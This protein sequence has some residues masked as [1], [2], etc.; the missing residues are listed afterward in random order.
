MIIGID[1]GT[2]NS[3]VTVVR[4]GRVKI[5]EEN[6]S[7]ILPSY[8]GIDTEGKL[9]VGI[10]ARNQYCV[11]PDATVRS[12]KRLM[13]S[14][15]KV[16]LGDTAYS[17]SELS[18]MI[19]RKLKLRAEKELGS[20]VKQAVIT[21]PAY[22]NDVQRQAT[23]EAG[24]LAGLE[25]L[26][27]LNEPTAASLAFESEGV[28]SEKN[29]MVYDLGGG[30]F[31]VSLVKMSG[32]VV[33]VLSSHGNS[34]LGGDDIDDLL[35]THVLD[36]Y[37][38]EHEDSGALTAFGVNRLKLACEQLKIDLSNSA[39]ATLA[40]T[41]LLLENGK[42][43]DITM[44]IT[45]QDLEE[46][47]E[48]LLQKTMSSV[49]HVLSQSGLNASDL[50]EIL[51][52]GGST[53]IPAVSDMLEKELQCRPRRDIHPELA[54]ASGAGVMAARLSGEKTHRILVDVTPYTFGTSCL[55]FVHDEYGPHLFIPVIK[56][57][58]PLP[59]RRGQ[60][61]YT[62][63]AEQTEVQIQVFQGE[64]EDC[65]KNIFI[66]EFLVEDLTK[67]NEQ[68]TEN[69][70]ILLNMNLDLDGL[71]TVTAIEKDTGLSKSVVIEG[72]L[73][74]LD[75]KAMAESCKKIAALFGSP[76]PPDLKLIKN[77]NEENEEEDE[78]TKETAADAA[79]IADELLVRAERCRSDLDEVD[80]TDL[81]T[82]LTAF[83]QAQQNGDEVA[84][85][86]ARETIEDIL[87]Y[88]EGRS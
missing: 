65:R 71:L 32:D 34:H 80:R 23:R 48:A 16:Q 2:T 70:P 4:D 38:K 31:D 42:T 20:E 39:A 73:E 85:Q 56:E 21:V 87:F 50:D 54:V 62:T 49:R 22:F 19:L 75:D 24:T 30:T 57:G 51:L 5:V 86:K 64:N 7:Q 43:A 3:E 84:T 29:V 74:P 69:N 25:V 33:E 60:V 41:G 88:V 17:P 76:T 44:Q 26:R 18:A 55:G 45:R 63:F 81:D 1:L 82:A 10:E 6:G 8:V 83:K 47:C 78:A 67:R 66:G 58:T 36:T 14:A 68:D 72:T 28:K 77:D 13:G 12:I 37:G 40:E 15:E 11:R 61:F 59:A 53:R 35:F 46:M 9:L 79:P 52:V 27:I